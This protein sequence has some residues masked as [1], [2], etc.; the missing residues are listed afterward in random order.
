MSPTY[1]ENRILFLN[2][3]EAIRLSSW[4]FTVEPVR[5]IPRYR[6]EQ[7]CRPDNKFIS[8]DELGHICDVVFPFAV[9]VIRGTVTI[10]ELEPA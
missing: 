5:A 3:K 6:W 10:R 4:L 8:H 7:I 9:D 2:E 1:L